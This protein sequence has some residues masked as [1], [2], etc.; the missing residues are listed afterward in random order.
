MEQPIDL[1]VASGELLTRVGR[2]LLSKI[3]RD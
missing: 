2:E 3:D 1:K